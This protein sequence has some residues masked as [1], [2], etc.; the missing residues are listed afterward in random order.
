MNGRWRMALTRATSALLIVAVAIMVAGGCDGAPAASDANGSAAGANAGS[1]RVVATTTM[2][3]DLVR[4][5]AGERAQIDTIIGVG[6][7]PHTYKPSTSDLGKLSQAD[8]I[9]YNGLHLE[10]KMVEL[11][12][13]KLKDRAVAVAEHVPHDKL[14]PWQQ[15]QGGAH[16]PHIWFD[17]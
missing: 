8:R 7:D 2:I 17:V 13:D 11:F 14:L 9:F 4:Q 10:G 5:I 16:D 3:A 15:G 12:E 1:K 6:V